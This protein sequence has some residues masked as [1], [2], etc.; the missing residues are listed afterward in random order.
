M[1]IFLLNGL[2]W[3]VY[4]IGVVDSVGFVLGLF[5][6]ISVISFLFFMVIYV[7]A[8]VIDPEEWKGEVPFSQELVRGTAVKMIGLSLFI[9]LLDVALPTRQTMILVAGSEIG[10]R[11][12]KSEQVKGI[13]DPATDLLKTWIEKETARFKKEA[14]R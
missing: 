9:I 10:E 1:Y 2:S 7:L 13:I 12:V 4:L 3:L 14:T 11:V 8:R 5:A 6:F